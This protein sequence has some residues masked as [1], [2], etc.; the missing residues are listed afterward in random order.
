MGKTIS[1]LYPTE[2]L[3]SVL[4]SLANIS[5]WFKNNLLQFMHAW[6]VRVR[7]TDIIRKAASVYGLQ[8][9]NITT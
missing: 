6:N 2:L 9:A 5:T 1:S 7:C 4:L 3:L 8:L